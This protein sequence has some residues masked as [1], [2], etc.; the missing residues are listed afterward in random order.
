MLHMFS[1][2]NFAHI[3]HFALYPI[4]TMHVFLYA[5][6][7]FVIL[8]STHIL[9]HFVRI[10]ILCYVR[11]TL[12]ACFLTLNVYFFLCDMCALQA[13][14]EFFFT[15]HAFFHFVPR[16]YNASRMFSNAPRTLT[17]CFLK[18]HAHFSFAFCVLHALHVLSYTSC[19]FLISDYMCFL[20]RTFFLM[21]RVYFSFALHTSLSTR[22]S[23]LSMYLFSTALYM[24]HF[25]R[26]FFH[27]P[28]VFFFCTPCTSCYVRVLLPSMHI[29]LLYTVH[30]FLLHFTLRDIRTKCSIKICT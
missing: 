14:C 8:R 27:A 16:A 6:C 29:F 22:V 13:P 4:H 7:M 18:V 28:C 23:L 17:E 10:F 30:I 2:L 19:I 21:L 12:G 5:T 20:L 11:F 25:L 24:L 3:F 1:S 26:V 9:L 15:L